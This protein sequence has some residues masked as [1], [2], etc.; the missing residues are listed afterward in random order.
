[1][2]RSIKDQATDLQYL[3]DD[4]TT[5]NEKL[6]AENAALREAFAEVLKSLESIDCQFFACPGAE[7]PFANTAT[8]HRCYAIQVVKKA[9]A[10]AAK[11]AK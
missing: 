4:A 2:E 11:E 7:K 10:E 9:L 6:E 1:M 3:L 8:C 5:E